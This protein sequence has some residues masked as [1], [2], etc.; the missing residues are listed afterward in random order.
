MHADFHPYDYGGTA[1]DVQ[2]ADE[3]IQIRPELETHILL[4]IVEEVLL[5]LSGWSGTR[6]W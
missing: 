5:A 4:M 1:A 2:R 3:I 6:C